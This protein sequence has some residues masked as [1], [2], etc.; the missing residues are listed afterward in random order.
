M[1][2]KPSSLEMRYFSRTPRAVPCA[3]SLALRESGWCFC[4]AAYA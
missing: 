4:G 2:A 1:G 3:L